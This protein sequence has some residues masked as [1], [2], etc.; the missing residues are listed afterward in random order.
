ML[1]KV[2]FN[3]DININSFTVLNSKIYSLNVYAF[4]YSFVSL[5]T[6]VGFTEVKMNTHFTW[7]TRWHSWLRHC[8]TNR[9][10]AGSIP[11]GVTGIFQ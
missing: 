2:R 7:G 6:E 3:Q 5:L 9:K 1:I 11:D 4:I 8:A 10:V